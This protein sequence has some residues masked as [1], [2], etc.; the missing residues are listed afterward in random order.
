MASYDLLLMTESW[1]RQHNVAGHIWIE[2]GG[3]IAHLTDNPL[4]AQ[5]SQTSLVVLSA[6]FLG[7]VFHMC[8]QC[9]FLQLGY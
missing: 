6:S 8:T 3:M 1:C 5:K 9:G 7:F 2:W 4:C